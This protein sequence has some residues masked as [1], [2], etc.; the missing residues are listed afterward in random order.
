MHLSY[1]ILHLFT[2]VSSE[3]FSM[4]GFGESQRKGWGMPDCTTGLNMMSYE[5]TSANL[6][7]LVQIILSMYGGHQESMTMIPNTQLK[8]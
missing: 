8:Q 4:E 6:K 3:M 2:E 5:E 7:F 1:L